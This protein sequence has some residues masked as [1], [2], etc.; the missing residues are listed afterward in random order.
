MV[1][2][3]TRVP[4]DASISSDVL[5]V[6]SH[7]RVFLERVPLEAGARERIDLTDPYGFG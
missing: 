2:V 3:V 6:K 7:E 5:P 4:A 1:E